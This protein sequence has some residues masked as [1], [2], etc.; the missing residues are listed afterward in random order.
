MG[1][2]KYQ[3]TYYTRIYGCY[4]WSIIFLIDLIY[5]SLKGQ[6]PQVDKLYTHLAQIEYPGG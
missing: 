2:P 4:H 1:V 6:Q 5:F 3:K